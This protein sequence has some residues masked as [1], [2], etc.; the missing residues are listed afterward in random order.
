MV[1]DAED[2]KPGASVPAT[3]TAPAPPSTD[4]V[5]LANAAKYLPTYVM[6]AFESIGGVKRLSEEADQDAKWFFQ[7]IWLKALKQTA[8]APQQKSDDEIEVLLR[9]LDRQVIDVETSPIDAEDA[10]SEADDG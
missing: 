8:S 6:A 1:D 3:M 4:G 5:F 9:K 2:P 10:D 7:H